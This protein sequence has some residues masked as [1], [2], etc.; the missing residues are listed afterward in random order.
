MQ[1]FE[2]LDNY[3]ILKLIYGK[4]YNTIIK[5]IDSIV[6]NDIHPDFD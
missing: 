4:N 2:N 5:E 1:S 6:K 3:N